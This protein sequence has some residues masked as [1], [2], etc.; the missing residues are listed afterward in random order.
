MAERPIEDLLAVSQK[1]NISLHTNRL[2]F[3]ES[4]DDIHLIDASNDLR[5][6]YCDKGRGGV[7]VLKQ[8]QSRFNFT[9]HVYHEPG[10]NEYLLEDGDSDIIDNLKST[11][12]FGMTSSNLDWFNRGSTFIPLLSAIE[13]EVLFISQISYSPK[14]IIEVVAEKMGGTHL[15][16]HTNKE[17]DAL[18]TSWIS[19]GDKNQTVHYLQVILSSTILV[20]EN[21]DAYLIGQTKTKFVVPNDHTPS[22]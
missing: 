19:F 1:I 4:G 13:K 2:K 20:I 17:E 16:P 9:F 21:I 7:S 15:D 11:M 10:L 3:M 5:M 14:K 12:I 8:L 22:I 18:K 6:F